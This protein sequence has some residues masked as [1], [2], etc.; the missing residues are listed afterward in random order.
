MRAWARERGGL[1]V[2]EDGVPRWK[3]IRERIIRRKPIPIQRLLNPLSPRRERYIPI[4]RI[5]PRFSARGER[6]GSIGGRQEVAEAEK[7]RASEQDE[8]ETALK[9]RAGCEEAGGVRGPCPRRTWTGGLEVGH[10]LPCRWEAGGEVDSAQE[11]KPSWS[12]RLP[13]LVV[14]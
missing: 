2:R 4:P 9:L 12:A 6:C 1:Y 3:L 11:I 5:P 10:D 14:E 7:G 8:L 13:V